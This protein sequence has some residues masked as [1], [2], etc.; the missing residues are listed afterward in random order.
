MKEEIRHVEHPLR[1]AI[2]M[3]CL[4]RKLVYE[5]MA[6]HGV[7]PEV[8]DLTTGDDD[9]ATL[10]AAKRDIPF[11]SRG[12]SPLRQRGYPLSDKG[13]IPFHSRGISLFM[14]GGYPL[15]DKRDIPLSSSEGGLAHLKGGLL[16]PK[17]GGPSADWGRYHLGGV[18]CKFRGSQRN[19]AR[20]S[21]YDK[22]TQP[23]ITANNRTF[24]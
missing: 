1:H 23:R 21:K 8:V 22:T 4:H 14:Q 15:S 2:D 13:D 5:D 3:V 16:Q 17:A 11:A 18:P 7:A 19:L 10:L 20:L 24:R 6:K 9:K 12:I